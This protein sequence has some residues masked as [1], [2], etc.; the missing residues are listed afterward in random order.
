MEEPAPPKTRRPSVDRFSVLERRVQSAGASGG[1]K[2]GPAPR[3]KPH[4]FVV[5]EAAARP[6]RRHGSLLVRWPGGR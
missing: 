6:R 3:R 4:C 5:Q 1:L 2:G